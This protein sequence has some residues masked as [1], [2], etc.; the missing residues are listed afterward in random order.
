MSLR[1]QLWLPTLLA[2]CLLI[3]G[4]H[5]LGV[6]AYL[7]WEQTHFQSQHQ[8]TLEQAMAGLADPLRRMDWEQTA[9]QLD[10]LRADHPEW[11]EVVLRDAGGR[12]RYP[13]RGGGPVDGTHLMRAT[14]DAVDEAGRPLASLEILADADALLTEEAAQARTVEQLLIVLVV[15]AALLGGLLQHRLLLR[16]LR[17]MA[18]AAHQLAAGN[19]DVALPEPAGG[20]VGHILLA[21]SRLR[22]NLRADRQRRRQEQELRLTEEYLRRFLD[23]S[24]DAVIGIDANGVVNDWNAQAEALFGFRRDEA[25]GQRLSRLIMPPRYRDA[26]EAGLRHYVGTSEAPM[27]NRRIETFAQHRD[28]REFPVELTVAPLGHGASATFIAFVRD[29]RAPRKA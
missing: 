10:R 27:L 11:S 29:T 5:F 20:E 2:A 18:N 1:F 17:H 14:Q 13:L 23:A 19:Y 28:G 24:F 16:P 6:P 3:A 25:L 12:Q 8:S 4:L 21:L 22:D 9:A 26:H 7:Q 15:L